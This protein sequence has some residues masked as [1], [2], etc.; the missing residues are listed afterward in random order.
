MQRLLPFCWPLDLQFNILL[1]KLKKKKKEKDKH[2]HTAPLTKAIL[3]GNMTLEL[4]R[5]VGTKL[6]QPN[7]GVP[8]N[9]DNYRKRGYSLEFSAV[10]SALYAIEF[11]VGIIF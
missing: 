4:F 8:I 1:T 11:Q 10:H 2:A 9:V 6:N 7:P 5:L 3:K